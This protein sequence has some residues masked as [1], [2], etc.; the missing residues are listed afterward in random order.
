M[1]DMYTE[2]WDAGHRAALQELAPLADALNDAIFMFKRSDQ[3]CMTLLWL[4]T[5][6]ELYQR[7]N[8]R[9]PSRGSAR[10]DE[11]TRGRG[12]L[13]GCRILQ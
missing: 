8:R 12:W 1:T 3:C 5:D 6:R 13:R 9:P 11:G 4:V 10:I 2:G 7:G